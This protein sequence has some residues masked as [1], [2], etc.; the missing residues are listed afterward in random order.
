MDK[1]IAPASPLPLSFVASYIAALILLGITLTI[2]V[3]MVRRSA[4]ISLGDG[5][6]NE[7][8]KRIRAHG[9]FCEHAP[10]MMAA[11]VL[12]PLLGAREWMVHLVGACGLSGRILHAIAISGG[13]RLMRFRVIGMVL[14]ITALSAGAGLLLLLAWR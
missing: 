9:N 11:L 12:L 6:N 5:D 3:V 13:N 8:R 1:I 10:L 2:R 7:L 4:L 14:T